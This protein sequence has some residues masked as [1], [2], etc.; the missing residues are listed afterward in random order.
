MLQTSYNYVGNFAA[1]MTGNNPHIYFGDAI[2]A[3][4]AGGGCDAQGNIYGSLSWWLDQ[5]AIDGPRL[6]WQS[7]KR[8]HSLPSHGDAVH[9]A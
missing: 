8:L 4:A 3:A 5:A 2:P 1:D 6:P 9:L 7:P